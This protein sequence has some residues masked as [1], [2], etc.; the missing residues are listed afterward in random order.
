M[1]SKDTI[2][3]ALLGLF[4]VK[5]HSV[6]PNIITGIRIPGDPPALVN[7]HFEYK[8]YQVEIMGDSSAFIITVD[9]RDYTALWDSSKPPVSSDNYFSPSGDSYF[10]PVLGG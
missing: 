10:S 2:G 7:T 9:G 3:K 5:P 1:I 6:R 4:F 8:G